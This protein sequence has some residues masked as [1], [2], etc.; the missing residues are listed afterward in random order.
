MAKRKKKAT[1][2]KK[3]RRAA[4]PVRRTK[5]KPVKRVAK[6]AKRKAPKKRKRVGR[7]VVKQI[8][9]RSVE[10]VVAGKRRRKRKTPAK[11]RR[12]VMA[13]TRRSRSV[14]KS[15]SKGLL[16]G[17]AVGAAALYFLTRSRS[18]TP[19][20]GVYTLPPINQTSN[21]TRNT[22]SSNIVNYAVAGGLAID[23]IIKLID[24]L[25]TSSDAEVEDIYDHVN[26]TGDVGV[27]V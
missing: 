19:S 8:E 26:T 25:N 13:G 18:T 22:Q 20:G 10:K 9:K 1:S 16:I 17:L 5:R 27:W 14:G 24:R 3:K 4:K 21:L 23:A 2:V 6:R 12:V 7:R 15:G 11:G